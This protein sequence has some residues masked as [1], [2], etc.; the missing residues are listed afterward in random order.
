MLM[1]ELSVVIPAYNESK[2]IT[3]TLARVREYLSGRGASFELLVADDGSV[4]DTADMVDAAGAAFP[5]L[6]LLKLKHRGKGGAVKAGVM[7]SRGKYVLM[8]DADLSTPIEELAKLKDA[9]NQGFDLAIGSR[10]AR[11]A[12]LARRQPLLRQSIGLLFGFLTRRIIPTG[13]LDTQCGFKLFRGEAARKLFALQTA[14]GFAFDLE[15]LALAR[16]LGYKIAEVP[17]VW[18]DA[19][20]SKVKPMRHLPEVMRE[21]CRIR[22]N[23]WRRKDLARD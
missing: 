14:S 12:V 15:I 7:E 17:V 18:E 11:G 5:E 16:K 23:L 21:V 8:C 10:R 3:R 20:G 6:K 1:I 4:D 13:V 19:E 2:R 22:L 9:L